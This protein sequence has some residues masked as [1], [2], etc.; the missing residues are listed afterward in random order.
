VRK[1]ETEAAWKWVTPILEG[2]SQDENGPDSYE[3]GTWG[4]ESA[5]ELLQQ[6]GHVWVEDIAA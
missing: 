1:D 4:P 5:R 2:W 6:A 3:A